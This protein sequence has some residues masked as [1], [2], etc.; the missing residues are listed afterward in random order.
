MESRTEDLNFLFDTA[1]K[2]CSGNPLT[3]S[4]KRNHVFARM[5]VTNELKKT[6]TLTKIANIFSLNHASIVH[7]K[8]KHNDFIKFDTEYQDMFDKFNTEICKHKKFKYYYC[9]NAVQSVKNINQD[10]YDLNFTEAEIEN[11]WKECL[12]ESK[13]TN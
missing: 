2:I 4:R 11:F 3:K 10:L 1:T 9:Q 5:L 6:L 8:K 12:N 13:K 7:N